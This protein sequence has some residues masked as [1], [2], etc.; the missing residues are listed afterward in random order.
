MAEQN[1]PKTTLETLGMNLTEIPGGVGGSMEDLAD[2]TKPI[3]ETKDAK[4]DPNVRVEP[5]QFEF[6]ES[7][8]RQ[9]VI[10][11][12]KDMKRVRS[13]WSVA[14]AAKNGDVN[15]GPGGTGIPEFPGLYVT[16][17][18]SYHTI[19]FS[20]PLEDNK[21][22]MERVATAMRNL[23]A[24]RA[25]DGKPSFVPKYQRQVTDDELKTFLREICYYASGQHPTTELELIQGSFPDVKDVAKMKGKF[26][27]DPRTISK[28]QPTY[29]AEVPAWAEKLNLRVEN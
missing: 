22:L 2:R 15:W 17:L 18:P 4:H 9:V 7:R 6:I 5:F 29:E 14:I 1:A 28:S 12:L 27:Y 20:D 16:V 26:L 11:S 21:E 25:G 13:R 10:N 24:I 8:C 19:V 3:L 23:S